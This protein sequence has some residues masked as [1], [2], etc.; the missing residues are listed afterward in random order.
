MKREKR[1]EILNKNNELYWDFYTSS[2]IAYKYAKEET[3]VNEIKRPASLEKAQ[4]I[5]LDSQQSV[6]PESLMIPLDKSLP[7]SEKIEKKRDNDNSSSFCSDD[8]IIDN[9]LQN[10]KTQLNVKKKNQNQAVDELAN[11][12]GMLIRF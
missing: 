12:E 6:E 3:I 4:K 9:T 7:I 10:L 5:M 8:S 11:L 2:T 1:N